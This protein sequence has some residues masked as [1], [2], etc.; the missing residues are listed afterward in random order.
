MMLFDTSVIIA[1][2]MPKVLGISGRKSKSPERYRPKA[3]R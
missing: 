2:G 3:V 1:R